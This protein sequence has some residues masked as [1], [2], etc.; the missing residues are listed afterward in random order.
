[1]KNIDP[2]TGSE[3]PRSLPDD[4]RGPQAGEGRQRESPR[5]HQHGP[6]GQDLEHPA[7]KVRKN[8]SFV[9]EVEKTP[10]FR[11]DHPNIRPWSSLLIIT[12]CYRQGEVPSANGNCSA[13]GLARIAAAMAGRGSLDEVR[14]TQVLK[15]RYVSQSRVLKLIFYQFYQNLCS[16]CVITQA[17]QPNQTLSSHTQALT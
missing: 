8:V 12:Y 3:L 16:V 6:P 1:M 17:I 4:A 7:D 9:Q 10:I 5:H 13:R 11:S 14:R 2:S 15:V